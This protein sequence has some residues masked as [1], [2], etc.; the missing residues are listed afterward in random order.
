MNV[1]DLYKKII[2]QEFLKT[3]QSKIRSFDGDDGNNDNNNLEIQIVQHDDDSSSSNATSFEF[4]IRNASLKY[5]FNILTDEE[6]NA[7]NSIIVSHLYEM[8]AACVASHIGCQEDTVKSIQI[9]GK[10]MNL[11]SWV[12]AILSD[13]LKHDLRHLINELNYNG[14][15][16]EYIHRHLFKSHLKRYG[17]RYSVEDVQ[18]SIGSFTDESTGVHYTMY[19]I[20]GIECEDKSSSSKHRE[21]RSHL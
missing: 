7:M 14:I 12:N 18:R 16:D 20:V 6:R 19:W 13:L 8:D 2:L 21:G 10:V 9:M 5:T 1:S 4:H 15:F 17:M 3:S 11:Y